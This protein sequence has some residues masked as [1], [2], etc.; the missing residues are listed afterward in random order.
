MKVSVLP[1]L[2]EVV[3][4][5]IEFDDVDGIT[6]LGLRALRPVETSWYL[7]RAFDLA[8]SASCWCSL[9]PLLARDRRRDEAVVAR[10]RCSSASRASAAAASASRCSSSARCTSAPT[11]E[12]AAARTQRGRDGL[13]KIADDPRVTPVGRLLRRTSLDELPQ[14]INVLRGE[15][16]LVGPATAGRGGGP[17]DRRLAPP[18]PRAHAR[19]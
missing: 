17:H 7:K 19:A 13:F 9:A 12:G 18:P 5:S 11:R 1:R 14:L 16:S 3:G 8:G 6:V 2:F 15:M 4:S 10:A